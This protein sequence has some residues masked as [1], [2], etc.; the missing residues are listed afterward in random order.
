MY[1]LIF[2]LNCINHR[3]FFEKK[4]KKNQTITSGR[5]LIY[6]KTP[7]NYYENE[8]VAIILD[9]Q[10]DSKNSKIPTVLSTLKT[11]SILILRLAPT[12]PP[13]P[14]PRLSQYNYS[15]R[16]DCSSVSDP[17]RRKFKTIHSN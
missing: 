15:L 14:S 11:K 3:R 1:L 4:R 5:L 13:S 8:P 2:F 7:T 17:V 6:R 10:R 9:V 16:T 12:L